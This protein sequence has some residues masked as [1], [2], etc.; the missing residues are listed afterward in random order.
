MEERLGTIQTMMLSPP[1]PKGF[2]S[3]SKKVEKEE[4]ALDLPALPCSTQSLRN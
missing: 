2:V 3:I 4:G 1:P